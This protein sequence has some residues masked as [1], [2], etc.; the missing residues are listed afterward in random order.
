MVGPVA[1]SDFCLLLV[2]AVAC[3]RIATTKLGA[4]SC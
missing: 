1:V 4:K 3:L 2:R